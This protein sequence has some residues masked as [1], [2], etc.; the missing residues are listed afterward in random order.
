MRYVIH[1]TTLEEPIRFLAKGTTRA[2]AHAEGLAY[3]HGWP[4]HARNQP[5]GLK[6]EES[7]WLFPTV[8]SEPEGGSDERP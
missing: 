6:I 4:L 3:I 7:W 2:E 1:I 5:C 8:P